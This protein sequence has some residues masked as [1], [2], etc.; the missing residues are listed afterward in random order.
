MVGASYLDSEFG[1]LDVGDEWYGV[2]HS[3]S[4]G[5]IALGDGRRGSVK[6][7]RQ[8]DHQTDLTLTQVVGNVLE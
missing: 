2:L 1:T 3:Q 6:P 5:D 7:H 4:P 8:V